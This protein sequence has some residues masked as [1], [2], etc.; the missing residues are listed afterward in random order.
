VYILFFYDM[1]LIQMFHVTKSYGAVEVLNDI[2]FRIERGDF[3]CLTG[4]TGSGKS[5]LMKLIYMEEKPTTGQVITDGFHSDRIKRSEIPYLRRRMGVLFQDF[6]LLGER[7]AHENVAFALHVTGVK[8]REV[9]SRVT[10][11]LTRVGLGHKRNAF[12]EELSGGELQRV[13]LARALVN[14]P[15]LLLADE[16]TGNLD[17]EAGRGI[18]EL[19]QQINRQG[20]A[21]LMATHNLALIEKLTARHLNLRDGR[22]EEQPAGGRK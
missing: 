22:L 14:D 19:F 6:K 8:H 16:P 20:T 18:V 12:P 5:T 15:V 21:V 1:A 4:P 11:A 3:V 9:R 2:T 17:Q 7:T 13:A 10:R